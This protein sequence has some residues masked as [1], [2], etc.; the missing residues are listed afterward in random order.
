MQSSYPQHILDRHL[1]RYQRR[2]YRDLV[3]S[4]GQGIGQGLGQEDTLLESLVDADPD[5]R[6]YLVEVS[7]KWNDRV[8]GAVRVSIHVTSQL[9]RQ[10]LLGYVPLVE[11]D[12][13]DSLLFAPD[14]T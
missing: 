3:D 4:L 12:A 9:F 5:G 8:D 14:D 6:E 10:P 2:S 7:A 1:A 13:A 11:P